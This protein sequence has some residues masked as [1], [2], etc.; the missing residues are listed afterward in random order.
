MSKSPYDIIVRPH[1]TEKAMML[2]YGNDRLSDEERV[3]TYTF[4]VQIDAN[5][6]E[7]AAALEAIYNKGKKADDHIKVANVRTVRMLGKSRR[8][9][10]KSKGKKPDWKKAYIT[11]EKGHLLEDYGV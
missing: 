10:A 8:V 5:K 6:F 7:V 9:G 11:L 1:I 2:S 3:R 4:V